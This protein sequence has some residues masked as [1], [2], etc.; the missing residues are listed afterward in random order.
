MK[1]IKT[2]LKKL[3]KI[4]IYPNYCEIFINELDFRPINQSNCYYNVFD[5]AN[6]LI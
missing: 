1:N 3:S 6:R 4:L 2:G 5:F